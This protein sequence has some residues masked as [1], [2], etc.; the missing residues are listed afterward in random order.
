[1]FVDY[2]DERFY[3]CKVGVVGIGFLYIVH[4]QDTVLFDVISTLVGFRLLLDDAING[5]FHCGIDVVV[6]TTS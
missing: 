2:D 3:E 1:L 6:Y 4:R 5:V